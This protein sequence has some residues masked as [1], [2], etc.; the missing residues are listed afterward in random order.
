M[1]G[2]ARETKGDVRAVLA[3]DP[4]K[5]Q[6][7]VR[8]IPD[9]PEP[10]REKAALFLRL[11]QLLHIKYSI[12]HQDVLKD[13]DAFLLFDRRKV[14]TLKSALARKK[15]GRALAVLL[16][17]L[18]ALKARILSP[19]KT[20]ALEDLYE[21]RHIAAGIASVYG[22]YREE[23]FDALR[24]YLKLQ[25][26][27]DVQL[28]RV[29]SPIN[30]RFI[31]CSTLIEIHRFLAVFIKILDLEG[32]ATEGLAAN[33]RLL[34]GALQA[35]RFSMAQY[36]DIFQFISKGIQDIIHVYFI[37]A[38]RARLPLVIRQVLAGLPE[39]ERP[40]PG[41]EEEEIDM[42]TEG[43]IRSMIASSFG[44]QTLDEFV[45]TILRTLRAEE[46]KFKD[47][48]HLRSVLMSYDPGDALVPIGKAMRPR[49][50]QILL[51][52]KGYFLKRMHSFGFPVPPGFILTTEVFR[53]K[54]A[55]WGDRNVA[56]DL[57]RRT[58]GALRALERLA[59]KRLGDARDPL[60]L[61]VRSGSV[62][63]APGMMTSFLNV[64]LNER[65]AG[66]LAARPRFG[67]AAWDC[68]RRFLQFWGMSEG[69][70][71]DFFDDIIDGFKADLGVA[72]KLAFSPAQMRDIAHAYRLGLQ[73]SGIS[74]PDDPREQLSR[75]MLKVLES[76]DAPRAELYRADMDISHDWGTAVIVQA[77]VFGNLDADSGT[78]VIFTRE[79]KGLTSAV[80]L[81]GDFI[82][83]C[84]GDDIVTGL[85]E[86]YP[87][88]ETQRMGGGR[89][90]TVSLENRFPEVYAELKRL[91]ET[92]VY[93]KGFE[94]QEI[95]FTFEDASREGL[96]IL[97]TRALPQLESSRVAVFFRTDKLERS[98][99]GNGIGISGGALSGRAVFSEDDIR[100]F[101]GREPHTPL[102]L[103]R[104]DTVPEDIGLLRG[105][106]G[107]LTA[108]GGSTSHAAVIVPQL[109][110]V[111]VVGLRRLMVDEKRGTGT[112]RDVVIRRGD[113]LS[114]DGWS[115]AV[116]R[117]RHRVEPE[118][119]APLKA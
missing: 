41:K 29:L 46:D 82:H 26:L 90:E 45:S 96:F 34:E 89:D 17:L 58:D 12:Q 35:R 27:A 106:E 2:V 64:G 86:T 51:G 113:F 59:R 5:I 23:K 79:P 83:G 93:E 117:G 114:L 54:E 88:S 8:E 43:F 22:T 69:L 6:R 116:Y 119:V 108:K 85:V 110:K 21:K 87:I 99:L 62:V 60:L 71:R 66:S 11:F 9:V 102:I 95:E 73:K 72:K 33:V 84:Q 38:H 42:R 74:V 20:E 78:G 53:C 77:M 50:D 100:E 24:L 112:I 52:N 80:S 75:V 92:L 81:F 57:D 36:T 61:S 31:T 94:H 107:L 47:Q 63:S 37:D 115:G 13:L 91:A 15:P 97:Q 105:V 76:W 109:K 56:R 44:L 30:L 7:T 40:G 16:E 4:A 111:G 25:S 103:V 10:D 1:A 70:N 98:R 68:Y 3:W 65:I 49:D 39:E 32:I 48:A 67:W 118:P 55:I 18:E 19:E 14:E 101:R 104:P 28:E